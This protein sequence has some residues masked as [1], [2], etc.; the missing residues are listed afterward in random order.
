MHGNYLATGF[1]DLGR[2]SELRILSN[3]E[4]SCESC[5][6]DSYVQVNIWPET[7]LKFL[8]S[9]SSTLNVLF[10]AFKCIELAM[11]NVHISEQL[12]AYIT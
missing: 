3:F 4:V 11:Y 7:N 2:V 5:F 9:L 6:G 10:G 12:C 1:V 8:I